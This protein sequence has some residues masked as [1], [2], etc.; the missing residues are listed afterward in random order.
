MIRTIYLIHR[1]CRAWTSLDSQQAIIYFKAINRQPSTHRNISL[2][3]HISTRNP[4]SSILHFQTPHN[5]PETKME[6]DLQGLDNLDFPDFMRAIFNI[7]RATLQYPADNTKLTAAK[8]AEDI[9][10]VCQAEDR[11]GGIGG[12]ILFTWMVVIEISQYVPPNHPW[13][14]CLVQAVENLHQ[15]EDAVPGERV[16]LWK[17]LPDLSLA[18]RE[19]WLDLAEGDE[20]STKGDFAR[21]KNQNSFAARLTSE[22]YGPWLNFPIWQ[23]RTA[24]EEPPARGP[25]QECRVWVACEWILRCAEP[26]YDDM[27]EGGRPDRARGTGSLCG[28]DIP[29]LGLERWEFWKKRFRE[30]AA[31]AENLK[32]ESAIVERI[33]DTLKRMDAVEVEGNKVSQRH[34]DDA[35]SEEVHDASKT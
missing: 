2:C 14:D 5:C 26:I 8:L 1:M 6:V 12:V 30:I 3:F 35:G 28:G 18:M 21:W 9:K 23:L 4:Q 22:S 11:S 29:D 33:S 15:Q 25:A 24:L 27:R 34:T 16:C 20:E 31:D 10:F 17:E 7:L 19:L 13:Q 32:L